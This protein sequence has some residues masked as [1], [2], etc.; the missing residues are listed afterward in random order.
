MAKDG[1]IVKKAS[2]KPASV[3][4]VGA[5]GNEGEQMAKVAF[6]RSSL[7]THPMVA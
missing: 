1:Q 4:G 5:Q 2:L 7:V 3:A 6:H